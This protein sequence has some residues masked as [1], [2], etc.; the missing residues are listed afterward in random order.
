METLSRFL[1][2]EDNSQISAAIACTDHI[3]QQTGCAV[4]LIHHTSKASAEGVE[5]GE[6]EM[7]QYHGRGG[8]ALADSCRSVL[9]MQKASA[10][11]RRDLSGHTPDDSV[12]VVRHL[13]SSY[14]PMRPPAFFANRGGYLRLLSEKTA[15]EK[16][17]DRM[18]AEIDAKNI[19]LTRMNEIGYVKKR[20]LEVS[21]QFAKDIGLTRELL[22]VA[23]KECLDGGH[24][25]SVS[26]KLN[27]KGQSINMLISKEGQAALD[28]DGYILDA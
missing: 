19:L 27:G 24:V 22:R 15:A 10:Q 9:G 2:E 20:D 4:V 21:A 18:R 7:T 23:I 28:R 12:I 14:G 13:K 8:G 6:L 1:E 25:T 17:N 5:R 16:Q 11:E 26:A 3:A